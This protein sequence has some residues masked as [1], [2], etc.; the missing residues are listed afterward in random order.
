MT[1]L[2]LLDTPVYDITNHIVLNEIFCP[3]KVSPTPKKD[4][5]R[6]RSNRVYLKTNR[7]AEQVVTQA[8]GASTREA[9]RRLSLSDSYWIRYSY[10]KD[11]TF[12]SITP[13]LNT[14]SE[15]RT[16]QG[17]MSSSVPELVVGGSQPKVWALGTDGITYMR[18]ILFPEQA[19]AEMMA[20]KLL[21]KCGINVMN[22][23]V[24]TNEGRVYA[25]NYELSD[26]TLH[27][28]LIN[29]VNMTS[30]GRSLIQ[31]DQIG[32]SVDGYDPASVANGY[33]AAGVK[34]DAAKIAITQV[35]SDTI[36][37]NIDR[38]H[39]TSNWAIF[40][41]NNTGERTPSWMYDFNW[42]RLNAENTEMTNIVA[43]NIR[44]ADAE[45]LDFAIEQATE[46]GNRCSESSLSA[47]HS[48][49][50]QLIKKLGIR[51]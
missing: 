32:I 30:V 31:F 48:N 35:I 16:A 41:D 44:M 28:G 27:N 39:N 9:K 15:A 19:Q 21:R 24:Q 22:A 33:M 43:A 11:T 25:D 51:H 20:V 8:G 18:K 26:K 37:G 13:Y 40:L 7:M 5:Q 34:G 2:M 1:V 50:L 46:I 17:P 36:T 10:D 45:T 6:W 42:S 23:F 29:L 49:A 38:R 47:W 3:F 14:F 4:Y 12:K